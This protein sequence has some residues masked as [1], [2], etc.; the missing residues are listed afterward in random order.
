[1]NRVLFVCIQNAG[2]SQMAA[3]IATA[4]GLEARSAGSRPAER[5]HPEVAQVMA[6]LGIDISSN[7]PHKLTD[8]DARWADIVVT[9]GCGDAC[10]YIPGRQYVDW[11][12]DDPHGQDIEAVRTIRDEIQRRVELLADDRPSDDPA[13]RR[14]R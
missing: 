7:K 11:E 8:E 6:E 5:V 9:M 4:A 12:L 1:M 2:R 10:P 14:L 13:E 3:A